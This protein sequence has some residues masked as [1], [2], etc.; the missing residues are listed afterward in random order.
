MAALKVLNQ[1][2]NLVEAGGQSCQ[3]MLP[4]LHGTSL[5]RAAVVLKL[6]TL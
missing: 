2:T 6:I 3:A 1:S 4:L 5:T